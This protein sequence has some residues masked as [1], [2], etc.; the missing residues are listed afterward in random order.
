MLIELHFLKIYISKNIIWKL[1]HHFGT[2]WGI[3]KGNMTSTTVYFCFAVCYI[4]INK[5]FMNTFAK[6]NTWIVLHYSDAF[7]FCVFFV[8]FLVCNFI[9]SS[10]DPAQLLSRCQW[11]IVN[12]LVWKQFY[13][14]KAGLSLGSFPKCLPILTRTSGN[15]VLS[16]NCLHQLL[17]PFYFHVQPH[18]K[19]IA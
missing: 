9:F 13:L 12:L 10:L 5:I 16:P 18:N 6:E 7:K 17:S 3:K 4:V 1:Q 14:E 2:A 19:W 11:T 15:F 8:H